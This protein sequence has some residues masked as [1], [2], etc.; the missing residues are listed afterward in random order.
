MN[1][2]LSPS[3]NASSAQSAAA[4]CG[5]NLRDD[6]HGPQSA[7][8]DGRRADCAP[9]D[10][11]R[12]QLSLLPDWGLVS[13]SGD[14]AGSFLHAQ[15]TNDVA[16]QAP[17]EARWNAWCTAKGRILACGLVWRDAE[18]YRFAV[19]RP[20][21][22]PM[23]KRLSMYVLRARA[24]LAD[25]SDDFAILGLAGE[26]VVE[27]LRMLGIGAPQPMRTAR[28]SGRSD[29]LQAIGLQAVTGI[30]PRWW[31]IVPVGRLETVWQALATRSQ[32]RS[33][34][35]WRHTEILAGAP[36]VVAATSERFVP[37][38]LNWE[39]I[40][41]VSFRK[42]CYPGQEVVARMHYRGKPKRRCFLAFVQ[43]GGDETAPGPGTDLLSS[44]SVEPAGVV[45]SSARAT[46]GRQVLLYEAS[47][48][49]AL[50]GGL[51][52]ADGRAIHPLD[53]PYPLALDG[54]AGPASALQAP[55]V[56]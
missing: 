8:A 47:I 48:D 30:G 45:V 4:A 26:P 50:A 34:D 3:W 21:A 40:G 33:S 15:T 54:A 32:L 17:D 25:A 19:S 43:A 9:V 18:T 16:Q 31:L 27:A 1:P 29:G 35:W 10:T 55:A 39:L 13:A 20:L 46:D 14:D 23:R 44:D 42:G 41:G 2:L 37:Q 52:L 49:A 56:S 36:R 51:R 22:A 28:E 38:T 12:C 53:L 7:P 5:L 11:G 24:A 6:L